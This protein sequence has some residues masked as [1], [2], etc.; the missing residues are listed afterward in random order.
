MAWKRGWKVLYQPR[1]VVYHEH[2]GTIGKRFREEQIQAVL[3]KNYLLFCWK[4]IHEWRKL[5]GAFSLRLGWR[6]AGG[7]VRRHPAAAEFPGAVARLHAI[8][9]G[10]PLAAPRAPA[11]RGQRYR[12]VPAPAGRLFPRSLRPHGDLARSIA[13]AVRFAVSHLP[14]GARRRRLHVP[15]AARNWRRWPKCTWWNCWIGRGRRRTTKNCAVSAPAP[16]GWCGPAAVVRDAGALLPHAVREFANDDLDWLIH[17]QLYQKRIDVLQLEYTHTGA[18][19]RRVPPDRLRPVRARHLFSVH[20]ARAGPHD[21]AYRGIEGA[22]RISARAALRT[23][24]AAAVRPGAGVH[25]GEPGLS[26][27]VSAAHRLPCARRTARGHRHL[28]L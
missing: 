10:L 24:H 14:A 17:R 19:P 9:A 11:E 27:V 15:D 25:A 5:A 20:P 26:A 3:K 16:S 6:A 4:N 23:A 28:T 2:R 12:S 13:G 1:S 7:A 18:I 8:A 21:R 22:L